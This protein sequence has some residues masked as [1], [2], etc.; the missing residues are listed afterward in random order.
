M[1]MLSVSFI[2][3]GNSDRETKLGTKLLGERHVPPNLIDFSFEQERHKKK[4]SQVPLHSVISSIT[5]TLKRLLK[6]MV[7]SISY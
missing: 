6:L 2:E 5:K 4:H 7:L 3:T 1:L